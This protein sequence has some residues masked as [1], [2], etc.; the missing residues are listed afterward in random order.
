MNW[1][2]YGRKQWSANLRY[3]PS[4]WLQK[5]RRTTIIFRLPGVWNEMSNRDLSYTKQ[6]CKPLETDIQWFGKCKGK[7]HSTQAWAD[8]EG[9]RRNTSY[10]LATLA[11][12][13]GGWSAPRYDRFIPRKEP[14]HMYRKLGGSR[15]RSGRAVKISSPPLLNPRS[16]SLYW[17]VAWW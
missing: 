16:R 13:E 11:L 5:L 3:H 6:E 17:P 9:R 10:S 14:I 15:R 2:E 8:T 1:K 12:E 7:G 4:I